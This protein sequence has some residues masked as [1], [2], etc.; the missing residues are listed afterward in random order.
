MSA[1]ILKC[2]SVQN[3]KIPRAAEWNTKNPC[4]HFSG[5]DLIRIRNKNQNSNW[6][7]H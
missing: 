4:D 6:I 7:L 2:E 5:D 3:T 1:K